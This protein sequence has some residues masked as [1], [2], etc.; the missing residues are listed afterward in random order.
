MSG[1]R[2]VVLGSAVIVVLVMWFPAVAGGGPGAG[3]SISGVL[4][5]GGRVTLR[6][7]GTDPAGWRGIQT[8]AANL[9]LADATLEHVAYDVRDARLT[10]GTGRLV[11]GTANVVSGSYLR[12]SGLDISVATSGDRVTVGIRA[13]VT[14]R[15]PEG[16]RF[17]LEITDDA[18]RTAT[19]IRRATLPA[20]DTG[21]PWETVALIAGVALLGG[22]LLGGQIAAHRRPSLRPSVYASLDE[23]LRAKTPPSGGAS[24]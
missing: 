21:L 18:G 15:V 22:G 2:R 11:A 14:R 1:K 7:T 19:A 4:E 16:A 3:G 9:M 8:L 6:L 10:L 20:A 23:R 24:P 5:Q 12:V 13:Q 17:Q